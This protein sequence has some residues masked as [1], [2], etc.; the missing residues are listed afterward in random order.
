MPTK[1]GRSAPSFRQGG[2]EWTKTLVPSETRYIHNFSLPLPSPR[3]S[4]MDRNRCTGMDLVG[5]WNRVSYRYGMRRCSILSF[6]HNNPAAFRVTH[7]TQRLLVLK[8]LCFVTS[9]KEASSSFEHW[10][11]SLRISW[12]SAFRRA[13][14][15]PFL[16]LTVL[17]KKKKKLNQYK[18]RGNENKVK[19]FKRLEKNACF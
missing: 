18:N 16:S 15:P 8:N 19:I 4:T 7:L 10:A 17:Y 9:W 14:C 3:I 11:D 12:L 6:I 1:P 5:A 13:R 2:G